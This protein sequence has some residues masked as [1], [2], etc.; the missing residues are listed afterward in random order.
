[1]KLHPVRIF[2]VSLLISMNTKTKRQG[3]EKAFWAIPENCK[4]NVNSHLMLTKYSIYR[5]NKCKNTKD[6]IKM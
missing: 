3:V 4:I 1:M 6:V 5:F 2:K